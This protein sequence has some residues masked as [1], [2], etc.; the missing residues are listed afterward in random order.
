MHPLILLTLAS[1]LVVLFGI[2]GLV[3]SRSR[4]P[5]EIELGAGSGVAGLKRLVAAGA[6]RI[7]LP[8]LLVTGGLLATM[9]FGAL[10]LAIVLGQP[11]TGALMLVV[12]LVAL[13]R[14]IYEYRR[15]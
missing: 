3:L 8:W 15:A 1:L 2:G 12:P 11:T 14:I 7:A 13:A 4:P 6:W 5:S 10:L 9:V